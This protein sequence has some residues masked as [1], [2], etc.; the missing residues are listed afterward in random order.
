VRILNSALKHGYTASELEKVIDE[1]PQRIRFKSNQGE[2]FVYW[3]PDRN[4][5]MMEVFMSSED[6]VVFHAMKLSRTIELL[7]DKGAR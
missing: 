5:N 3:G 1:C 4:G 2:C 6:E 7:I